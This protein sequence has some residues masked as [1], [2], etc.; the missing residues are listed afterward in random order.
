MDQISGSQNYRL[1][2]L[3]SMQVGDG[4]PLRILEKSEATTAEH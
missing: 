3:A 1:R 4:K 2:T